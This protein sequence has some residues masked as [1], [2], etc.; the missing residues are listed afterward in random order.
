MKHLILIAALVAA[1]AF[2]N[3]AKQQASIAELCGAAANLAVTVATASLDK[4][5]FKEVLPAKTEDKLIDAMVTAVLSD[6]YYGYATMKP[7]MIR[8][9]SYSRCQIMMM[10]Y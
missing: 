9:L 7:S 2:A 10:G 4:R 3:S 5:P 1:P 8:S 6:A